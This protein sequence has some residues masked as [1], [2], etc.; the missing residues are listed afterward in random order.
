MTT[1]LHRGGRIFTADPDRPWAEALVET[2][3]VLTFVGSDS[4]ARE[5]CRDASGLRV[6]ELDGAVVLPGFVDAHTHLVHLGSSLGHLD[7]LAVRDAADLQARLRAYAA[8]HPDAP[9]LIGGQWLFEPL[10]GRAPDRHLLDEAVADRP[11]YLHSNDM[12]SIW[13]NTAALAEL[14]IDDSTPDPLG[15]TIGRDATGAATGM[16]YETAALGLAEDFLA[17]LVTDAD[18]DRALDAAVAAYL[19]AGVTGAVDMGMRAD[20]LAAL[21]RAAADGRL[22][23]RVAAHWLIAPTGDPVADLAQVDEARAHAERLAGGPIRIAGVKIMVDGVIDSC[24]AAMR[25]PFADG[26]RPGPIWPLAALEPVVRAADAAGL[27]VAMHAIGDEASDIALTA[28]ERAIAANGPLDRR[29][30][31]EHLE[32]VAEENVA[33]L[34]RLGAVASMQPVHADP[35]IQATWRANLGDHR[36]ERGY[37]WP[38]FT[39]AGAVLAFG[40]DAPTA[41]HPPL[42]NMFVAST[43]RSAIDP[44]LP[45]NLPELALPLAAALGHGTRDAAYSCRWEDVAGTLRAGLAADFVVLDADPFAAG[46]DALL[47][48]NIAR[49]VVGGRTVAG[50]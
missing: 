5:H 46:P 36:V 13:V 41:P 19:E 28:L 20:D 44:S 33:R 27:Q 23:I 15:G 11:V 34:A 43:R 31:L 21:E 45:A 1:T 14:G 26:S 30:R 39:A 6:V 18:R 8:E 42:P 40:S 25:A 7:L 38:E 29:H 24:T 50:R 2:G 22:G 3:G 10:A 32:T 37:P 16:L 4:D 49:T 9:R 17:G 35:A 12:H 47:T 48:A